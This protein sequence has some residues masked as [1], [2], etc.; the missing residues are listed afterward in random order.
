MDFGHGF[1][2]RVAV[3]HGPIRSSHSLCG[4]RFSA[5]STRSRLSGASP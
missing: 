1:R 2:V 3:G 5:V 4:S